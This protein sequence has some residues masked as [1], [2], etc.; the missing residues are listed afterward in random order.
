MILSQTSTGTRGPERAGEDG[1]EGERARAGRDIGIVVVSRQV[2]RIHPILQQ[3]LYAVRVRLELN[4]TE[5]RVYRRDPRVHVRKVRKAKEKVS[6][7]PG[8]V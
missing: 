5:K 7:G 4:P 3:T 6:D 8:A 1:G 2:S